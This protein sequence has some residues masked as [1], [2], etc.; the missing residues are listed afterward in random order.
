MLKLR[1]RKKL[2]KMILT[3][4]AVGACIGF[5][6]DAPLPVEWTRS[7]LGVAPAFHRAVRAPQP[8]PRHVRLAWA[9]APG[10]PAMPAS[11]SVRGVPGG[12]RGAGGPRRTIMMRRRI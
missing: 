5:H 6:L 11:I 2:K 4:G 12:A 1:P 7:L 3:L 9:S 10:G 8:D